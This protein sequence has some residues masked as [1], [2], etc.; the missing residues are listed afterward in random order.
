V[1]AYLRP[2][3]RAVSRVLIG[4]LAVL[5]L[6]ALYLSMNPGA[7]T[8]VVASL[9][10]PGA[11]KM[12]AP[13][14][15]PFPP[16]IDAPQGDVPHGYVAFTGR[17]NTIDFSCG[18]LLRLENG[19]LVGVS[20]AHATPVLPPGTPAEFLLPG[21]ARAAILNGQ[22]A[23]GRAFQQDHF[24]MDFVLWAVGEISDPQRYIL[25]DPRGAGQPG[26]K[27]LVYGR[28]EDGAGG[29][30]S[31]P[32]VV[33][34]VEPEATWIQLTDS[35]SPLGFSGCPVVSQYTGRVIGMAVAGH[36]MPPVV[37]GLHPIGSIVEKAEKALTGQ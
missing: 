10:L 21:G 13:G 1:Q 20:A 30:Q 9:P 17:A 7:L 35:F 8:T 16:V 36:D 37:M 31:W 12:P 5:V 25:P 19:R 26:E 3:W 6:I 28:I 11:V 18:F 15:T 23:H 4:V 33:M 2:L 24:T 29:S 14:P 32:G 34:A 22:I 27:V